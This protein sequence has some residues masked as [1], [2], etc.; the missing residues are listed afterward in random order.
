MCPSD[1]M[2]NEPTEQCTTLPGAHDVGRARNGARTTTASVAAPH[3]VKAS[4]GIKQV[5]V[6][7]TDVQLMAVPAVWYAQALLAQ[8]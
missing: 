1:F 8:V 2:R 6:G 4:M 5:P 3:P 7:V